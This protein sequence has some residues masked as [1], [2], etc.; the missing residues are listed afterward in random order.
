MQ[1][2]PHV[3]HTVGGGPTRIGRGKMYVPNKKSFKA[4]NHLIAPEIHSE[5]NP[6]GNL[7]NWSI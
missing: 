7:Y 1:P 4:L 6:H 5:P 3:V 2:Q